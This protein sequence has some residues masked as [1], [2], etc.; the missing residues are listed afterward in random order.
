MQRNAFTLVELIVVIAVIGL[1][2]ALVFP[3]VQY[4]RE[5]ARLV[6]CTNNLKQ[7][8][9]AMHSHVSAK[10]RFPS[11]GIG[12]RMRIKNSGE[13][14]RG[15]NQPGNEKKPPTQKKKWG[16]PQSGNPAEPEPNDSLTGIFGGN[17]PEKE[18]YDGVGKEIAW[19]F[20]LLPFLEEPTAYGR[21]NQDLWIDHP[22][23]RRSVGT[24]VRTFLCPSVGGN[25]KGPDAKYN[26][27]ATHTTPFETIPQTETP[28][29]PQVRCG[30]SHYA[31][32]E[33]VST[34]INNKWVHD[35]T[36]GMLVGLDGGQLGYRPQGCKD[37]LGNT[38][39]L[40]E[41]TDHRD[42]AWP[43]LRNLFV[44]RSEDNWINDEKQRGKEASNG[45]K[46]YHHVGCNSLFADGHVMMIPVTIDKVVLHYLIT[47]N[48]GEVVAFP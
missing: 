39:L 36:A 34:R 26:V 21:Y 6:Q 22:E 16:Y 35:K 12:Y 8:G 11:G 30:R 19:G 47:R 13:T 27:T 28:G 25:N 7:I 31:G 33:G 46:S 20:F 23:N 18:L 10:D 48:G 43:S 37:G 14:Y 9:I 40:T 2:V 5:S 4:A 45:F 24:V 17:V 15:T 1:L 42:G 32:L 44:H 29:F 3:A 38:L 41:D